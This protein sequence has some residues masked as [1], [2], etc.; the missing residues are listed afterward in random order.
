MNKEF[1]NDL[2]EDAMVIT[3]EDI[4]DE[5]NHHGGELHVVNDFKDIRLNSGISKV[6]SAIIE[7]FLQEDDE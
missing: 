5:I 2:F 4:I 1:K 3:L 7:D 6:I